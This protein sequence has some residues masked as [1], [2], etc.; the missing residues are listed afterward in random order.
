MHV[1]LVLVVVLLPPTHM[2]ITAAAAAVVLQFQL[3]C[4]NV[5]VVLE[6]QGRWPPP[7]GY[8][9][10]GKHTAMWDLDHATTSLAICVPQCTF[11]FLLFSR[12]CTCMLPLLC[13]NSNNDCLIVLLIVLEMQIKWPPSIYKQHC[14]HT[15]LWDLD[16]ATSLA[17][18]FLRLRACS[19]CCCCCCSSSS[20]SSSSHDCVHMHVTTT[21]LTL[22]FV[23]TLLLY[24]HVKL[25]QLSQMHITAAAVAAA[26]LQ[27][28]QLQP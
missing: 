22:T 20:S 13:Y 5:L 15:A 4:L 28:Q 27:F 26:V 25:L 1:H 23:F 16:H 21:V 14:R 19:P 11:T 9:Q 2:Y 7:S 24:L 12:L 3:C 18:G 10:H 17:I 6:M 8:K